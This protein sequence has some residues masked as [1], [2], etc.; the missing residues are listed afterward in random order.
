MIIDFNVRV[1]AVEHIEVTVDTI[2]RLLLLIIY[3][4]I[5]LVEVFILWGNKWTSN[6]LW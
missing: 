4:V 3:I 6:I 2:I 5:F 1:L